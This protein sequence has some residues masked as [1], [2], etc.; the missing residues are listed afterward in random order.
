MKEDDAAI[1]AAITAPVPV[2]IVAADTTVKAVVVKSGRRESDMKVFE[3]KTRSI[4]FWIFGMFLDERRKP[5]M[6]RIMLSVW[7][8]IG[9]TMELHE[10]GFAGDANLHISNAAWAGWWAAQGMLAFAV[11]GPSIASYFGPG[12]AGAS[13][14]IG[15][16]VRDELQ[17]IEQKIQ[18]HSG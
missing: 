4:L 3:K 6:S 1:V 9:V 15:A 11:F 16:S 12:A 17:K 5:S 18:D 8:V 2:P 14:G 10:M 13:A 7:T